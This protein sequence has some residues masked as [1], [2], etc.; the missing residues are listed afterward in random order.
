MW[1]MLLMPPTRL[2]DL[3]AA[4]PTAALLLGGLTLAASFCL[5]AC[6]TVCIL[7]GMEGMT[8][9]L[10]SLRLH[11]IEFQSKFYSGAGYM[12]RPFSLKA[13]VRQAMDSCADFAASVLT[14][15]VFE[16]RFATLIAGP[17]RQQKRQE[18]ARLQNPVA[19]AT[20]PAFATA[21]TNSRRRC[22]SRRG[23]AGRSGAAA[24]PC[25]SR[26]PPAL[27]PGGARPGRT[28]ATCHAPR[29]PGWPGTAAGAPDRSCARCLRGAPGVRPP[30]RAEEFGHPAD[31][32]RR[33]QD[34][35][36]VA[37]RQTAGPQLLTLPVHHRHL[38]FW[39]ST[40]SGT[41]T[42]LGV[43]PG[44]A[45]HGP[46]EIKPGDADLP[47]DSRVN[48]GASIPQHEDE[49]SAGKQPAEQARAA[50]AASRGRPKMP[51]AL[52][53]CDS[54]FSVSHRVSSCS[55]RGTTRVSTPQRTA[56]C[57]SRMVRMRVVPLRGMPPMKTNGCSVMERLGWQGAKG[58]QPSQYMVKAHRPLRQAT[59]DPLRFGRCQK[60]RSQWHLDGLS[61]S[62]DGGD[63]Q[64][65]AEEGEQQQH[66]GEGGQEALAADRGDARQRAVVGLRLQAQ[67]LAGQRVKVHR[68]QR[69]VHHSS[70]GLK[71][72]APGHPER[73]HVFGIGRVAA[74]AQGQRGAGA[75]PQQPGRIGAC[76]DRWEAP[77]A[78]GKA[79]L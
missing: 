49:L 76:I 70:G 23:W 51:A 57:A 32:E 43:P 41:L 55:R 33:V 25:R 15:Q 62:D 1:P 59:T 35:V 29:P 3:L 12:F 75:E 66:A 19:S 52:S 42:N 79:Q 54:S 37:D 34:Q 69:Q 17:I 18:A 9:L 11:W 40:L 36:L 10:H 2:A 60:Q 6:I 27:A 68:L 24:A 72:G 67:Q 73:P 71:V 8:A 61:R 4:S 31:P 5:W 26:G 50:V 63:D 77:A 13:E 20:S 38:R 48:E 30:A 78:A 46:V 22:A 65:G 7:V 45:V 53:R 74:D 58:P 44:Q 14:E 16:K 21:A 28:L 47:A 64:N 39:L 56:E